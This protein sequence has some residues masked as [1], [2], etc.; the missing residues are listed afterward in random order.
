MT[1]FRLMCV[2]VRV[3]YVIQIFSNSEKFSNES[4][5]GLIMSIV[6]T[7]ATPKVPPPPHTHTPHIHVHTLT[8]ARMHT[9]HFH[10][11]LA[12]TMRPRKRS[13]QNQ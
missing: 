11:T 8:L 3:M 6:K 4:L 12:A 10:P 1:L 5:G 7:S 13:F 2:R 9:A